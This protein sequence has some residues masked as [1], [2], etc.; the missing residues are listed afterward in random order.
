MTR[1]PKVSI[2]IPVYNGSNYLEQA[3]DSALAQ[4]Y[5]NIE[6]IVINDGSNDMGATE[7][8]A[9]SYANKI[10][11]YSK[12]N[13]GVATALNLGIKKMTGEYFSWL[14]HDDMYYKDKIEKQIDFLEKQQYKKIFLYSNYSIL[15]DGQITPVVHNHEMLLRK[16]K[17]SL[18]RGCVNGITVLI[19]KTILAEMGEFDEQLR[20]TQDYDYWRRI[21]AK[22]DFVHMEDVLSITR[23]HS[24]QDTVVSTKVIVESDALWIDMVKKL[25]NSEKIKL[26]STLYNFYFEMVQFLKTTPYTGALKHNEIELAKLEDELKSANFNPKVSVVIPF[27]NRIEKTLEALKSATDQSYKNIEV[28]LVDDGSTEDISKLEKFVIEHKNVKLVAPKQNSG[29]AAARNLGIKKSRGEYIAFLDSDDEFIPTKIEKQLAMMVKHN[30]NISY[31]SYT[32]RDSEQ[33]VVLRDPGLTGIVVPRIISNCTIATP[34]VV[35]KRSILID[36]NLFFDE[37]LRIGEDTCFWLEL[38]KHYEV[39]LVDEPLTVVNV[40]SSTHIRDNQALLLGIKNIIAYLLGDDYYSKFNYDISVLCNY[41][42]ELNNGVREKERDRLLT[43]G[44][45]VSI[46]PTVPGH[47]QSKKGGVKASVKGSILYRATSKLYREGMSAS[48][49]AAI[50]KIGSKSG[51]I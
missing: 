3:I 15:R 11:Y 13:G 44:P 29:P 38:A 31:T 50:N 9:K 49:R 48:I 20:C 19:P 33:D 23:L 40:D 8:I 51:E 28:V 14:S 4:T 41:F 10:R 45:V 32:R 35:V 26:E 24:Q 21:G 16:P 12:E 6:V 25:P 18:L 5:E 37:N 7:R 42:F 39:L 2:I 43:E 1:K 30:L 17:Y 47:T 27:Y 22:Y 46:K 36:S 34:T